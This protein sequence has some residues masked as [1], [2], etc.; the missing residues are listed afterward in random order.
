MNNIQMLFELFFIH[1]SL[2]FY[3][4]LVFV[5]REN[6]LPTNWVMD[7]LFLTRGC[8]IINDTESSTLTSGEPKS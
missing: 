8:P 3:R 5:E 2:D 1:F 7:E 4:M 6:H